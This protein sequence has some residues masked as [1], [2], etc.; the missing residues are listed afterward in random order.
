[1]LR[2]SV[3][4]ATLALGLALPAIAAPATERWKI[5]PSAG[6]HYAVSGYITYDRSSQAVT[7]GSVEVDVVAK[8]YDFMGVVRNNHLILEA[9][10][11]AYLG[12]S[13][14]LIDI[15]AL[16]TATTGP[17]ELSG[18][19]A[20]CDESLHS[21]C[22]DYSISNASDSVTAT[23]ESAPTAVPTLT[24]WAMILMGMALAGAAALTLHKR[25]RA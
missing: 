20:T 12:Q 5:T 17:E 2:M 6:S 13:L 23:L 19:Y 3:M 1:M 24:E 16:A 25:R 15:T 11:P 7:G 21:K 4:G 8:T 22:V 14:Y 9:N 18:Y 10:P